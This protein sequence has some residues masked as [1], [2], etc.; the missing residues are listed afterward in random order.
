MEGFDAGG[1]ARYGRLDRKRNSILRA[2]IHTIVYTPPH[3][4]QPASPLPVL[5]GVRAANGCRTTLGESQEVMNL[6]KAAAVAP[7]AEFVARNLTALQSHN[8]VA[9]VAVVPKS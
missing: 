4:A 6:K 9:Q 1:T 5:H 7:K 2:E 3:L 8:A